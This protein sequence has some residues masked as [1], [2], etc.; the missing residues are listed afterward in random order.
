MN[1]P[2]PSKNR[3]LAQSQHIFEAFTKTG[4]NNVNGD[5]IGIQ[6]ID[7]RGIHQV[8]NDAPATIAPAPHVVGQK[9]PQVCEQVR[10]GQSGDAMPKHPPEVEVFYARAI[11]VKFVLIRK[12]RDELSDAAL[13]A[14]PFID[15]G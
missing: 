13:R 3:I 9:P 15:E 8:R 11:D 5:G 7:S 4:K 10:A 6:A 12:A 14:V 2:G 1:D